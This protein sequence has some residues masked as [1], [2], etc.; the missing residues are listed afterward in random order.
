VPRLYL[1]P[2]SISY[3]TQLLLTSIISVYLIVRFVGHRKQ[4]TRQDGFL[5]VGFFSLTLLILLF[6]LEY[7]LLPFERLIAFNL[8]NTVVAVMMAM[9]I[10]FAYHFPT[11]SDKQKI[12]RRI[13]LFITCMYILWELWLAVSIERSLLLQDHVVYRPIYLQYAMIFEFAWV[14]FVFARSAIRNWELHAVR[15][16]ALILLIPLGMATLTNYQ[17]EIDVVTALFPIVSSIGILLTIFLFALNYLSSQPEQ[18][19]FIVKIS[20]AVL[21]GVLAVLGIIPWLIHPDSTE[22]YTSS[23]TSLDHRTIHFSPD[24]AGGY[25]AE[26][27]PFRWESDFGELIRFPPINTVTAHDFDFPFFGQQYREISISLIGAIS[28]G[29]GFAESDLQSHFTATPMI[30]PMLVELDGTPPGGAYFRRET[31]KA[32]ITWYELSSELI[33]P[34]PEGTYTFQVVLFGDGSFDITYNGL[35]DLEFYA[36]S[37]F[38]STVWVIGIKPARAPPGTAD[39]TKIPMQIGPQGALQ[40]EY[41]AFRLSQHKFLLPIAVAVLVSSLA[42]FVVTILVLNYGLARPLNFLLKGVQNFNQGQRDTSIPIQSNDEIGFLTESFNHLGGELNSLI[43][44][45]EQRVAERT[46]ELAVANSQLRSEIETRALAQE[47]VMEHQRA[48]AAL[49][50]RE[51]VARD[52]HDGIGQVLG[53]INVQAQSANDSVR[54]GDGESASQLLTR[55]VEVAQE[56]HDDV[57]GYILGLKK[58]ST[59]PS[60]QEF[61]TLLEQ[62][63]QH[64]SQNFGFHTRLHLP[65]LLSST[66]ADRRVESQLLFVIREALSN[67]RAHSGQKKAEVTITFDNSR[68]Q[69]VIQDHGVGFSGSEKSGHFGLGIMRERAEQLGGTLEVVSGPGSGTRVTVDLPRQ[70][71]VESMPGQ[72]ILLVDDHP[73]FVEG[74]TN[75]IAGRG[76]QVVGTASDGLEALEKARQ[77][78]P[79]AILMDIEMPR[80]D[81]LEATRQIKTEMPE[82]RVIMLTV[83]GEEQHLFD[84]LQSGA[85]GYLLK[86]LDAAELTSLLEDLLRGEVSISPGLANKMLEA[87][88]RHKTPPSQPPGVH[89]EKNPAPVELLTERQMEIL[90]MVA[91]GHKYKEIAAKLGLAEVTVKYHMGEI[92]AR[93]HLHNR[94]DAVQYF[95][96]NRAK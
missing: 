84:A 16:F 60:G 7:S 26:E 65:P 27:I 80:C 88:T 32:V 75:L 20:G 10:Q 69:A 94:R 41:I 71:G 86:S 53:F 34:S 74:I 55:I 51:R 91:Q 73:L 96:E 37:G 50:E 39:F 18:V 85:S 33:S 57:R 29:E 66:L 81:G 8:Q 46:Q 59:A 13:V 78:R 15:N 95:Q 30:F 21:T 11:P 58:E 72:R 62:Y 38:A 67:A 52:L 43:Q 92:L 22:I 4:L 23:I 44:G 70:S 28:M 76:M 40:D 19:S 63:C 1:S 49:E 36:D 64:L 5:L 31:E 83:S 42:F 56:A 48:V 14:V 89:P 77:L 17:N 68:V 79:D 35:T 90:R 24:G 12:E 93:L 82:V 47:Q 45:L 25:L 6:F 3:F 9:L 54:K 87:F 61:F 2:A